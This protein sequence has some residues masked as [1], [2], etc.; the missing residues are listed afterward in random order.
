M[1]AA[2][3]LGSTLV[4]ALGAVSASAAG[5]PTGGGL[6]YFTAP[7]LADIHKKTTGKGI[8]VAILDGP[9][10]PA[11]PDLMGAKNLIT[12]PDSFCDDNGDGVQEPGVSTDKAAEHASGMAAL[13]TGTGAGKGGQPGVMGVA[14]SA[15]VRH[16]AVTL[17]S[18]NPC[19]LD[20]S[21]GIAPGIDQAVA[22]G[23]QIISI[24]LSGDVGTGNLEAIA[25]AERAGVIVVAASNNRGGTNLGWPA[26]ANGVVS[27]ES[28]DVNLQLNDEAV[29]SPLL[30]VV[31]PGEVI[32]RILWSDGHWDTY[33][34]S[35]GSSDATAWTAG[36]LAL[37]WSAYPD[38]SAN[39]IIQ[40][41]LR[42]TGKGGGQLN[43]DN[44][45]GYGVVSIG[46]MLKVDPATYPDV[47]P[48]L[49][50]DASAKPA[51]TDVVPPAPTSGATDASGG[52]DKSGLSQ[53]LL[54]V[55]VGVLILV[56]LIGIAVAVVLTRRRRTTAA[57]A[58]RK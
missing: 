44:S 29:T 13:I 51:Y 4:G 24:S 31:A 10:D 48:L 33:G 56:I 54:I 46:G 52:G 9:I 30:S 47:N 38:A 7:G 5:D 3:I 39:Q 40:T 25:K 42:S 2:A 53:T 15:T 34:F 27:V 19:N 50:K 45:W 21:S 20:G 14:P 1:L 49:R 8:S 57:S 28:A 23:A 22:D 11:T 36:A 12:H 6:W 32:R 43:R 41:L 55:G 18:D 17:N 35:N 26:S 58:P 16:Y 37:V